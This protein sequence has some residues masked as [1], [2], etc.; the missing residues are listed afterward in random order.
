M[1]GVEFGT[2]LPGRQAL[3]FKLCVDTLVALRAASVTTTH[4]LRKPDLQPCQSRVP[5]KFLLEREFQA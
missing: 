1:S 3:N 5:T 4:L 2:V